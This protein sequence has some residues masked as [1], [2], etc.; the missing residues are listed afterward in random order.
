MAAA[1]HRP[2]ADRDAGQPDPVQLLA[3]YGN[4]PICPPGWSR[5]KLLQHTDV[6]VGSFVVPLPGIG[7][8]D[9][10]RFAG[11]PAPSQ[12]KKNGCR[13]CSPWSSALLDGSTG[14][15]MTAA[16]NTSGATMTAAS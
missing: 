11:T 3:E 14:K 2:L 13:P 5:W 8:C 16:A 4:N 12:Y 6:Q 7:P 10:S 15:S 9:R 1:L